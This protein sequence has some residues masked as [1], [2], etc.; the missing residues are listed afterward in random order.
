M[1]NALSD[2]DISRLKSL[3]CH[4]SGLVK[5]LFFTSSF[6]KIEG[7]LKILSACWGTEILVAATQQRN[8]SHSLNTVCE[9]DIIL[10]D[11]NLEGTTGFD[12][13]ERLHDLGFPGIIASITQ[14]ENPEDEYSHHF[15]R[16]NEVATSMNATAEFIAWIN[17]L[18]NEVE[19]YYFPIIKFRA[20]AR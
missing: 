15:G 19:I 5:I 8:T 6:S 20:L 7:M 12:I 16:A 13:V 9:A 11:N 1:A 14:G 18:L 3:C 2:H 17:T 4:P 10:I